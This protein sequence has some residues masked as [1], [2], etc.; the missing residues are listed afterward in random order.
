MDDV[1]RNQIQDLPP[2]KQPMVFRPD[3][4]AAFKKW[5]DNP[6]SVYQEDKFRKRSGSSTHGKNTAVVFVIPKA[7]ERHHCP[8]A[9]RKSGDNEKDKYGNKSASACSAEMTSFW[10]TQ[11]YATSASLRQPRR[12]SRG[13]QQDSP[14]VG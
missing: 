7:I 14:L 9:D 12:L 10:N 6:D 3:I 13:T 11:Q 8:V 5:K 4:L 1:S 2:W